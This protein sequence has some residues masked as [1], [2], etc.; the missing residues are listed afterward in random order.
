MELA[1]SLVAIAALWLAA[2]ALG[3]PVVRRLQASRAAPW[4]LWTWGVA[5]GLV[6][7]GTLL[8]IVGLCGGLHAPAIRLITFALACWGLVQAVR[9]FRQRRP[10]ATSALQPSQSTQ[11]PRWTMVGMTFLAIVAAIGALVAALAPPTAGDA[12]CYH[13]E[14]PKTFL[15]LRSIPHLPDHDNSTFPLLTE[16]WYMWALACDGPVAAQLVHWSLGL[17]LAAATV[18]LA[19]TFL[20]PMWSWLAG[21]A[22]LLVPG[23]TNQMTAPLNDVSLAA[24]TTL[25]LAALIRSLKN[26]QNRG[27][28]VLAGIALGGALSIKYLAIMFAVAVF[29]AACWMVWRHA[30]RRHAALRVVVAA[31]IAGCIA[32]P[33]YLRAAWYRGNPVYPFFN[34][35]VGGGGRATLRPT[36]A[37]LGHAPWNLLQAPWSITHQ[38]ERFGGRGH[39]PGALWLACLPCLAAVR[40]VRGVKLLL[41]VAALYVCGWYFLRQNVRFLFPIL[42]L[43]AVPVAAWWSALRNWPVVPGRLAAALCVAILVVQAAVPLARAQTKIRAALVPGQRGDYLAVHEPTW[44]IASA[45]NRILPPS[46]MLLSQEPRAYY[47]QA[48][49]TGEKPFR[50]RTEYDE[51]LTSGNDLA[52]VLAGHGFSHVLVTEVLN[53]KGIRYNRRLAQLVDEYLACGGTRLVPRA[54]TTFADNVGAVRRYRL[55]EI[56]YA[57]TTSGTG[58]EMAGGLSENPPATSRM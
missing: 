43:L 50:R 15:A 32:A 12:L 19:Q 24:F 13:L 37:S 21:G 8:A 49:V 1:R 4:E 20:G 5:V 45:A 42:P 10:Q 17:L 52:D 35:I 25:A 46:A 47:F 23:V 33:W 34:E 3:A 9:D 55:F 11:P 14:L 56:R 44:Q 51:A 39:Q 57:S 58:G 6:A 40:Q 54:E 26:D 28:W 38:P 7:A 48:L 41:A 16:M 18:L 2:Y 31:I 27:W 22:V 29:P 53:D 30:D 36:K